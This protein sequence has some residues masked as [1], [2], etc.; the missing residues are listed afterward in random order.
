M[1]PGQHLFQCRPVTADR[2]VDEYIDLALCQVHRRRR[3]PRYTPWGLCL[4]NVHHRPGSG[5]L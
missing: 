3:P 2:P 1:N 4:H 5:H